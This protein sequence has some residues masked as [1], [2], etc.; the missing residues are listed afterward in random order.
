MISVAVSVDVQHR[1][2]ECFVISVAVSVR[3]SSVV[4]VRFRRQKEIK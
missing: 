3:S 4:L 2:I 1:G